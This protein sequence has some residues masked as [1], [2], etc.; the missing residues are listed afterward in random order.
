MLE[1]NESSLSQEEREDSCQAETQSAMGPRE[2]FYV[3]SLNKVIPK[4]Q[5][6]TS[7]IDSRRDHRK[8]LNLSPLSD[9]INDY[10]KINP[11]IP[12]SVST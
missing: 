11:T 3:L 6:S 9:H 5:R 12:V 7:R 8:S 10:L 4:S 1:Q 2:G